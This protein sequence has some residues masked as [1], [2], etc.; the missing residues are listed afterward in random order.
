LLGTR[1][2]SSPSSACARPCM[3][4]LGVPLPVLD[5]EI[6]RAARELHD[7]KARLFRGELVE[8]NPLARR[9]RVSS[10]ATYL[11]LAEL[12][13]DPL[14]AATMAWVHL[15]TIE[16]V[17]WEDTVRLATAREAGSIE[18]DE[19]GVGRLRTSVRALLFNLLSD[20]MEGR[21]AVFARALESSGAFAA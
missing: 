4:D 21:R 10:K 16:R 14:K 17:L 2:H 6:S 11:E 12:P 7:A 13:S 20:P 5:Q 8:G 3:G 9:R 18:V 1:A 15:L 19:P